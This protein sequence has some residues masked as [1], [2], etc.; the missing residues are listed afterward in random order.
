MT[1]LV[2]LI[3][4]YGDAIEADLQHHYGVRLLDV[5]TGARVPR[6]VLNLID[7]LPSDSAL[8]EAQAQD[9]A[10]AEQITPDSSVSGWRLTEFGPQVQLLALVYEAIQDLTAATIGAA[11]GKPPPLQPFPRPE[12]AFQRVQKR[13]QDEQYADLLA[14]IE[15]ARESPAG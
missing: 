3:D 10:L 13:R 5:F 15:R 11:G 9:E 4:H 1:R 8:A 12:T 7:R 14:D 2:W 6:E